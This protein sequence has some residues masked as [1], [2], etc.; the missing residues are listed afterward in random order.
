MSKDTSMAEGAPEFEEPEVV[1]ATQDEALGGDPDIIDLTV[2]PEP[3]DFDFNEFVEGVRLGRRGVRITMR[4]D[5]AVEYDQFVDSFNEARANKDPDYAKESLTKVR[6][7]REQITAS[8]RW[9]V[10]EA[11]DDSRRDAIIDAMRKMGKPRPNKKATAE[12]REEWAFELLL[13]RLADAIITPSNVT[14]EGLVKLYERSQHPIE[15]LVGV[16]EMVNADPLSGVQGVGP[17]FSR[18]L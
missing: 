5:L 2:N 9:F 7:L 15:V 13:R 16:M 12:M 10:V 14:Y 1:D 8:Q 6:E 4:P 17:D 18:G 3:E 11:R